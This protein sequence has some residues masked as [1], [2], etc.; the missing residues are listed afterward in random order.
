MSVMTTVYNA[1]TT[2]ATISGLIG[3]RM[4]W[5]NP[6]LEDTFPLLSYFTADETGDYSFGGTGVTQE[7]EDATIQINIYVDSFL[8]MDTI[9]SQLKV[10]MNGLGFRQIQGAETFDAA[11]SKQVRATRWV[12]TNVSDF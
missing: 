5:K 9:K 4:Y 11:L 10:V 3:T 7:A 8:N 12:L 2:D 6:T 1:V